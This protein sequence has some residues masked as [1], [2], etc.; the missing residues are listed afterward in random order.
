MASEAAASLPV[1]RQGHRARATPAQLPP[2][3]T[4]RPAGRHATPGPGPA[5]WAG[6]R[7]AE[8]DDRGR[9]EQPARSHRRAGRRLALLS[10][11]L[12]VICAIQA[13][14]SLALVWSN[15]AF[16]DE[17]DYLRIGHLLIGHWLHGKSWPAGYAEKVL[18]GAPAIYPPLGA[19]ADSVGGL[20]GARILSLAFMVAATV[21]VYRTAE[22]LLGGT[23]AV[24]AAALWALSEPVLRLAFATYDPMSVFLV[25][26]AAWLATE[27]AYRRRQSVLVLS[28][29]VALGLAVAVAYSAL[30]VTPVVIAVAFLTWRCHVDTRLACYRTAALTAAAV[31]VFAVV[32]TASGSWAGITFTVINRKMNDYQDTALILGHVA[33]YSGLI[34]VL[35]LTG[36]LAAAREP[37]RRF[38]LLLVT[39]GATALVVPAA[40]LYMRTGWALDKHV[41]YGM[42]FASM[43]A[44]Y[45]C[46]AIARWLREAGI[47]SRRLWL[48]A[49][50]TALV[51]VAA[52]NWQLASATFRSWPD[53][54]SF[55]RS[56]ERVA[57]RNTGTI[58]AS[59]QK[60]VAA[61][62]APEGA[63]WWLWKVTAISL[64]PPGVPHSGWY[65]YYAGRL[66][67]AGYGL[68]ALFY[69][70][71]P[72]MA[73][74]DG[75]PAGQ[76]DAT[77]LGAELGRLAPMKVSEPGVP[78]LTRALEHDHEFRLVAI[79]PYDSVSQDGIYAIWLRTPPPF[80]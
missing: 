20:A 22:R 48:A 65:S 7:D 39:L 78:V 45:G 27:A 3:R 10:H 50:L 44:G 56:F 80:A 61:Y 38:R 36:A 73:L 67:T 32:I 49:E 5:S 17:A 54:T 23:V 52:A 62:Y 70:R 25:A 64:D 77:R 34:I 16:T 1:S 12:T 11:P 29:A 46:V 19:M 68:I 41:A 43:A 15:T 40:Q 63:R 4:R 71:P 14:G 26:L 31:A 60:R 75:G 59:A 9:Q 79:G 28:S 51:V 37:D 18:S 21:L 69:E 8:H 24:I 76:G 53:A 58:Y 30:A 13:A 2:A 47:T 6:S 74:P 35:A 55:V 57:P 66:R 42:W 72:G 33:L